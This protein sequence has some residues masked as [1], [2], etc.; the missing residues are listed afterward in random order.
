MIVGG[1]RHHDGD[2]H[3]HHHAKQN[4]RCQGEKSKQVTYHPT[5]Y[6]RKSPPKRAIEMLVSVPMR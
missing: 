5:K 6:L 1:R 2:N 3:S 4:L